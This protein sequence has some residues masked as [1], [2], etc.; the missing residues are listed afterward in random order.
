MRKLVVHP[1]L[2]AIFPILYLFSRNTDEI[3]GS[4]LVLS[5]VVV[6][7]GGT[8]LFFA[9]K[10]IT[11]SYAKSGLLTTFVIA[12]FYSYGTV[13]DSL[14][15]AASASGRQY[16]ISFYLG[17]AWALLSIV[18]LV[19]VIKWRRH[20]LGATQFLNVVSI[21]LVLI[22]LASTGI[23]LINDSGKNTPQPPRVSV[24]PVSDLPDIYYII[25][26]EFAPEDTIRD[27]YNYDSNDF[28][29]FLT[30]RGFYVASKSRSNYDR[31]Y[32]SLP[33]SLNMRYIT[34]AEQED[35]SLQL[36]LIGDSEVTRVLQSKGYQLIHV[37]SSWDFKGI[38]KYMEIE[39]PGKMVF[40]T[41]V[42]NFAYYLVQLTALA[43]FASLFSDHGQQAILDAFDVLAKIP[44]RKGSTFVFAHILAPHQPFI[45][46]RNG[47][48]VPMSL[49][50]VEGNTIQNYRRGYLDQ[51]LFVSKK[52]EKLVDDILTKS[53]IPPV[54]ILQADHGPVPVG[55]GATTELAEKITPASG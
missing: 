10:F 36:N 30:Q 47:N 11:K 7:G 12:L 52:V 29:R 55:E 8:V 44:E 14:I 54:I 41:R 45:F 21:L 18:A 34:A 6:L 5:L 49:L 22:S 13:R 15:S 40:G 38:E 32:M 42:S 28:T 26:D 2:L 46:D 43:P 39:P 16:T 3:S 31:T 20:F 51:W 24:Q 19:L 9:L 37:S 48:P 33:S 17:V 4:E 23:V 50:E 25:L 35:R 1:F 27:I 53:E